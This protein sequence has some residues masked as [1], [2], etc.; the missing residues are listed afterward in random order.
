MSVGTSDST[1]IPSPKPGAHNL[2]TL[3]ASAAPRDD[4]SPANIHTNTPKNHQVRLHRKI[5]QSQID[6]NGDSL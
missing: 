6:I 5:P 3:V 2:N 4:V 1:V